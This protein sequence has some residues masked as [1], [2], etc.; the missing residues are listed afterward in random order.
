MQ[1]VSSRTNFQKLDL[2]PLLDLQAAD[3][4]LG[5]N[6]GGEHCFSVFH[7]A[8]HVVELQAD[9]VAFVDVL[10]FWH[11]NVMLQPDCT[12]CRLSDSI[13]SKG[14]RYPRA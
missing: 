9:I 6:F 11:R 1:V 5:F 7:W 3:F 8:N 10:A 12:V 14:V 13:T 2:V 4:E